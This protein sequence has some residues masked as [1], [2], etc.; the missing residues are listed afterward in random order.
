[1]ACK[2]CG[3]D[4]VTA[5]GCDCKTCPHCC[6]QQRC[7]ARSEGRWVE[8]TAEKVC[9]EC[10]AKFTAVG[11]HD[12][13]L[14]VLCRDPQCRKSRRKKTRDAAHARRATGVFVLPREPKETRCC[15]FSKCGKGLTKRDQKE[16]CDRACYFAAIDAGEQQFRGRVRDAWAALADWFSGNSWAK[17][18][19]HGRHPTYKPRPLC[20]VCSKECNH[21]NS[22][23]CSY[24]CTKKWRGP[25]PCKCGQMVLDAKLQGPACCE[26]CRRKLRAEQRRRLKKQI[27]HYR[28]KCRKYGGFYN[29]KCR[30]K[31]ILARDRYRCHLCGRKCRNDSQ[32]NHPRAAT[33]DHHPVPLSKGGDHDWHNVRCACRK[34]NSEKRDKWDGQQRIRMVATA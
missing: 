32:W 4:W 16:Y 14:R 10:G 1:M 25:R 3:S 7:K 30:R 28:K 6:K 31:D 5:S 34:C 2:K 18:T 22:R 33:V 27:G 26:Q 19:E 20:E 24:E 12:I 23:C 11:L 29:S 13:K 9:E 17:P 8:P 15:K 21:R